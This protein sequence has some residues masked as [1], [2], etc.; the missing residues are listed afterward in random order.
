LYGNQLLRDKAK[1]PRRFRPERMHK[2]FN[3]VMNDQKKKHKT[4]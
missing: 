1:D 4:A 3:S 2:L